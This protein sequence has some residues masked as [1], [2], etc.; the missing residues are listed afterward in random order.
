M[1]IGRAVWF[2]TAG[3]CTLYTYR[4]ACGPLTEGGGRKKCDGEEETIQRGGLTET[5][6]RKP[7]IS[8]S[9]HNK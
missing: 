8:P 5:R 7:C 4:R 3:E 1:R 6:D 2:L 9:F